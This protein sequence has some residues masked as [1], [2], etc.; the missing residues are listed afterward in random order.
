MIKKIVSLFLFS[1]FCVLIFMFFSPSSNHL[2]EY[3]NFTFM[4]G[5]VLFFLGLT[6]LL[7]SSG[8]LDATVYGFRRVFLVNGKALSKEEV[9]EMRKLSDLITIRYSPFLISGAL[10]LL[11]MGLALFIYYS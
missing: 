11:C 2:L 4:V 10:V 8:F 6:I 1:Q 7:M 3:I 9:D 5:G